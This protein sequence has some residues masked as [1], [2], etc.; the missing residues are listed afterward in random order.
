MLINLYWRRLRCFALTFK[1]KL[2]IGIHESLTPKRILNS[3]LG[4]SLSNI[5]HRSETDL[6][7]KARKRKT[8]RVLVSH[9]EHGLQNVLAQTER[10][11]HDQGIKKSIPL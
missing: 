2:S 1:L 3:H 8:Y 11:P 5:C 4:L 6:H 10:H 7:D 9:L